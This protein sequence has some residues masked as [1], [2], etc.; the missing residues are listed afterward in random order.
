MI[1]ILIWSRF[2]IFRS[3][4]LVFLPIVWVLCREILQNFSKIFQNF[5]QDFPIFR[6][7]SVG[8][9]N[10]FSAFICFENRKSQAALRCQFGQK[11]RAHG[12][13]K[14]WL[15]WRSVSSK[16]LQFFRCLSPL[17]RFW[18]VTSGREA[19]SGAGWWPRLVFGVVVLCLTTQ[20]WFF[21]LFLGELNFLHV[22][23][24]EVQQLARKF[25]SYFAL[26]TSPDRKFDLRKI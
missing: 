20:S 12:H 13:V 5:L 2:L 4:L 21:T 9:F 15:L 6:D 23:S 17:M 26:Q 18:A 8:I 22:S 10:L 19:A 3:D 14:R 25:N 16:F 7:K 24:P 11:R 1:L